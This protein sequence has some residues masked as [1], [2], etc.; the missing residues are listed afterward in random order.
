MSSANAAWIRPCSLVVLASAAAL[1]CSNYAQP[2]QPYAPLLDRG[3]QVDLAASVGLTDQTA[4]TFSA[5]AAVSPID[6]LVVTAGL[7]ADPLRDQPDE[8]SHVAGELGAGAF[9]VGEPHLRASVIA[10]TGAGYG[11]GRYRPE[12]NDDLLMEGPYVRPF[13]QGTIAGVYEF[14]AWGGGVR[15][16]TTCA[17]LTFTPGADGVVWFDDGQYAQGHLD[18]FTML[19]VRHQALIVELSAGASYGFVGDEVVGAALGAYGAL[20]VH[21]QLEAWNPRGVDSDD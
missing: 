4:P 16:G 5:H 2:H 3:G 19:R 11:T 6:H 10:G 9:V 15:L 8:T 7:D 18:L 20:T 12:D 13:V 1:G 14:F 17:W 21:A